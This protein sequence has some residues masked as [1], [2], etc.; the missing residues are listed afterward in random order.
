MKKI[1]IFLCC[2]VLLA[3][4]K[5]DS[6]DSNPAISKDKERSQA[7]KIIDSVIISA[8][9]EAYETA[10]IDFDFRDK[11][12]QS[13]RRCGQFSLSRTFTDSTGKEIKDVLSNEGFTRYVNQEKQKLADSLVTA[14]S[15]SVNSVHYFMQLPFGLNDMAVNKKLLGETSIENKPYYKIKVWFDAEGG[16][17][18]HEDEY[19]YWI[20]KNNYHIDYFAYS[21][22]V[23]GGGMRFRKAY[24]PREIKGIRFV[25]YK[26]Y[27]PKEGENPALENL[28]QLYKNNKLE[29]FSSIEN[30]NIK[31]NLTETDCN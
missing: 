7:E 20:N 29:L 21:Y 12:Y 16:G 8:G 14:Y 11:H 6:K 24:N 19:L 9:G 23:N 3:G 5:N 1:L 25:D 28:D 17:E 30:K 15:N 2:V 27:A 4:C 18:D 22:E 10:S 13:K 26:N 31:V